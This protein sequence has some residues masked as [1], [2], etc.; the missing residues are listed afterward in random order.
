[1]AG[2]IRGGRYDVWRDAFIRRNSVGGGRVYDAYSGIYSVFY[3][4]K[5]VKKEA[6]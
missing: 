4:A 5:D 3:K 6:V 2:E 1:M